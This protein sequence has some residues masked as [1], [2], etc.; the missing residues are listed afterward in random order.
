MAGS[1]PA[2]T[3]LA[4]GAAKYDDAMNVRTIWAANPHGHLAEALCRR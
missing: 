1:S 4:G 3:V 2:M